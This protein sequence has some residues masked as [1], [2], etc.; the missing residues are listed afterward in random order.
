MCR[1]CALEVGREEM[2]RLYACGRCVNAGRVAC[3]WCHRNVQATD[4]QVDLGMPGSDADT[5]ALSEQIEEQPASL[6]DRVAEI[7][8]K[9]DLALYRAEASSSIPAADGRQGANVSPSVASR[10]TQRLG[11][12]ELLKPIYRTNLGNGWFKYQFH[13]E[14]EPH[15]KAKSRIPNGCRDLEICGK[16]CWRN[17]SPSDGLRR[18]ASHLLVHDSKQLVFRGDCKSSRHR[19]AKIVVGDLQ[20]SWLCVEAEHVSREAVSWVST[21][22]SL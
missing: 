4:L 22:V 21:Q 18:E 17:L 9:A 1:H 10:S 14:D 6:E 12:G 19:L 13:P 7:E 15:M 5:A 16:I 3:G 2:G 8:A 20:V 11:S